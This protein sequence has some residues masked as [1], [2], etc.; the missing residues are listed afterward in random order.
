M[1]DAKARSEILMPAAT[2]FSQ[3][4]VAVV[5]L[6]LGVVIIFAAV[7]SVAVL[8]QRNVVLAF[9]TVCLADVID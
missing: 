7:C 2:F 1:S 5:C 9:A 8:S 6:Q 3:W 4:T